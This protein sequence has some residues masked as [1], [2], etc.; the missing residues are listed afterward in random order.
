MTE[1][2]STPWEIFRADL[3]DA[4]HAQ[5]FLTLL[6][7]YMRH[8][9]GAAKPLDP[10]MHDQLL[11]GLR[12]HPGTFVLL[13]LASGCPVGLAVSFL[14]FSTFQARP[15]LN[16]HDLV[17]APTF[18]GQGVGRQLLEGVELLARELG[19]C[20]VTLEVRQD[21]HTARQLYRKCGFCGGRD[22]TGPGYD[23]WV[24]PL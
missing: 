23:F 24:K 12:A 1:R 4:R 6:D 14:G 3:H 8:P 19:C 15:L 5:H 16:L 21:N 13:A 22:E 11:R 9:M 17:V 20:R 7:L 2:L 18:R 10:A